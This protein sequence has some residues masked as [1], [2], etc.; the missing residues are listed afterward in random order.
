[1]HFSTIFG[2]NLHKGP[3]QAFSTQQFFTVFLSS[4]QS[5]TEGMTFPTNWGI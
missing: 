1:M 3:K 4:I 2:Q 5:N